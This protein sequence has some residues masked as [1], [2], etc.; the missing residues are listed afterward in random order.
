MIFGNFWSQSSLDNIGIEYKSLGFISDF[1]K[2]SA[3]YSSSDIFVASS[4]QDAWPKTFA[5]S[6]YCKTPVVCFANTSIS[7]I[8][9]HKIN[10]YI[11]NKFN[12]HELYMGIKWLLN[13]VRSN[14]KLGKNAKK[15]LEEKYTWLGRSEN[16]IKFYTNNEF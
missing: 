12:S 16:I 8:V 6:M 5:E 7:E 14:S 13:R 15:N 10:G 3:V 2:L 11:V 4:I 9:D 1:K